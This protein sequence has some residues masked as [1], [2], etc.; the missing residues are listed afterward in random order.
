MENLEGKYVFNYLTFFFEK[1]LIK[2][3]KDFMDVTTKLETIK[4]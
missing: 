3:R 4:L 1:P 2:S